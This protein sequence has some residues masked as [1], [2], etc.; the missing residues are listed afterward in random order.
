ME[1]ERKEPKPGLLCYF[2][3]LS[4]CFRTRV[5]KISLAR[6]RKTATTRGNI[7]EAPPQ[8]HQRQERTAGGGEPQS[9]YPQHFVRR[10]Q[11]NSAQHPAPSH[12]D[13]VERS[14]RGNRNW[15]DWTSLYKGFPFTRDFF[16]KG[17]PCIRDCPVE[18][19]VFYALQ[20]EDGARTAAKITQAI[21][22]KRDRVRRVRLRASYY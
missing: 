13:R 9:E 15:R 11:E 14:A 8:T 2:L 19:I 20:T 7:Y 16:R 10:R 18:R 3:L 22:R 4:V 5:L 1:E 17:F 12:R 6:M 21:R